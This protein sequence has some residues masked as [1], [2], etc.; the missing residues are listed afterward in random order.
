MIALR[1]YLLGLSLPEGYIL[2]A[3][4][5]TCDGVVDAFDMVFLKRITKRAIEDLAN[6]L[7]DYIIRFFSQTGTVETL[8]VYKS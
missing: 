7:Y 1:R 2:E 5:L 6:N 8:P 3:M 4:D